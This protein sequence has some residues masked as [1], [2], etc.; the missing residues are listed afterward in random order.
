MT[1]LK[2]ATRAKQVTNDVKRSKRG[3]SVGGQKE[4]SYIYIYMHLDPT[5][6]HEWLD[7]PVLVGK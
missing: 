5:S 4:S 7:E 6:K 3:S 2:W 1:S